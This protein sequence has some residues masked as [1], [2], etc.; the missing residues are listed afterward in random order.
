[1]RARLV[2]ALASCS[3][4]PAR[5]QPR[6]PR[7]RSPVW[8]GPELCLK[9]LAAPPAKEARRGT[10]DQRLPGREPEG[11]GARGVGQ[12]MV[13]TA[14]KLNAEARAER[15]PRKLQLGYLIGAA[16]RGAESTEG[17][18]ADLIRRLTVAARYAPRRPA[19]HRLSGRLPRGLRSGPPGG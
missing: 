10:R 19:L 3:W 6:T 15:G 14:T 5:W 12:A 16:E 13:A 17:I 8:Q 9:A 18:H 11:R 7:L 4:P 2:L 1:M